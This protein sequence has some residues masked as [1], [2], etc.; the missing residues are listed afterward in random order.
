MI[1]RT[2]ATGLYG[3]NMPNVYVQSVVLSSGNSTSVSR[4][5]SAKTATSPPGSTACHLTFAMK[6]AYS[7]WANRRRVYQTYRIKIVRCTDER[8]TNEFASYSHPQ[9]PKILQRIQELDSVKAYDIA[10]GD[11]TR[12]EIKERTTARNDDQG[13]DVKSLVL[14]H[15]DYDLPD[16]LKH[17]TYFVFVYGE[18]IEESENLGQSA[19][20]FVG[21]CYA[22]RVIDNGA[23]P[24]MTA[25]Y[26]LNG[27]NSVWAG[28]IHKM[29][30]GRYHT[31]TK[32]SS[33]SRLLLKNTVQN[34]KVKDLRFINLLNE[35][36]LRVPLSRPRS[37]SIAGDSSD[38]RR[39]DAE[40]NA[41]F[42]DLFS[43]VDAE[44]N[45][46]LLFGVNIRSLAMRYSKFGTA[47]PKLSLSGQQTVIGYADLL[48]V[49]GLTIKRRRAAPTTE[50]N[51]LFSRT[52]GSQKFDKNEIEQVIYSADSRSG[53]ISLVPLGAK[54][55]S[56]MRFYTSTD[57]GLRKIN[58]GKYQYVVE[59]RVSDTS[60]I[61]IAKM[62]SQLELA[63]AK[64]LHPSNAA[65][66]TRRASEMTSTWGMTFRRSALREYANIA[67]T[68]F[69]MF[70][71]TN[72]MSA[73]QIYR[74]LQPMVSRSRGA[75][76]EKVISL[77]DS[78]IVDLRTL[79]SMDDNIG[80]KHSS[81]IEMR[82][83]MGDKDRTSKAEPPS[84]NI[85]TIEHVFQNEYDPGLKNGTGYD[86]LGITKN[87]ERQTG[88]VTISEEEFFERVELETTKF[89]SSL[90]VNI[91]LTANNGS[92]TKL[93]SLQKTDVQ[94]FTPSRVKI[95]NTFYKFT[96][97]P[98]P[99]NEK[100]REF[101]KDAFHF[102]SHAHL[103][104]AAPK[105]TGTEDCGKDT[106]RAINA[107]FSIRDLTAFQREGHD[108]F[109]QA[110]GCLEQRDL[111]VAPTID[112]P[113]DNLDRAPKYVHP[114][115]STYFSGFL[116]SRSLL[117]TPEEDCSPR[118]CAPT[119]GLFRVLDECNDKL[120]DQKPSERE[121]M[122]KALPNQIKSLLL[123][124]VN[125][126]ASNLSWMFGLDDVLDDDVAGPIFRLNFYGLHKIEALDG[127]TSSS[128]N[129]A[130]SRV[131]RFVPLTREMVENIPAGS[132]LLCR[133]VSYTNKDFSLTGLPNSLKLPIYNKHFLIK[134][135]AL[136]DPTLQ[137]TTQTMSASRSVIDGATI[138]NSSELEQYAHSIEPSPEHR[139]SVPRTTTTRTNPGGY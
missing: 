26:N 124:S 3:R 29:P 117:P 71:S 36:S 24:K 132:N 66:P 114:P 76:I 33:Q 74:N 14:E 38:V 53:E 15:Y 129:A 22:Q 64:M 108:S 111:T 80:T 54:N 68:S 60:D 69:L 136:S 59:L 35:N 127:F 137:T 90:D 116:R 121:K 113:S 87:Q 67:Y 89:F 73:E 5:S 30:D 131:A 85:T 130:L 109:F 7:R 88:L 50:F 51:T 40:K 23:V 45:I 95:L 72:T 20:N 138:E 115:M 65:P 123:G 44:D 119:M 34:T 98:S 11:F 21:M 13:N 39:G 77:F 16:D 91:D 56:S 57:R 9:A 37:P 81:A 41:V 110:D 70:G 46:G 17:L 18:Q 125:P 128:E 96:D 92:Y 126:D 8:I 135:N 25:I 139:D 4:K 84:S 49:V 2:E 104:N 58:Y 32:H 105:K 118:L 19:R 62:I 100:Y 83:N 122:L 134:G 78:L 47:V 86:Y 52:N 99:G 97:P 61:A 55:A 42:T 107:S 48:N 43:S 133:L 10:L 63:R 106:Q 102:N 6:D 12:S 94:F 82:Q 1:Y 112:E 103:T 27:T 28:P 101:E 79:I 93:D 31:G 75:D 120:A